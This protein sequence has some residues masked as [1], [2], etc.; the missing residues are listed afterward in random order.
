MNIKTQFDNFLENIRPH[1]LDY[2]QAKGFNTSKSIKCLNPNHED[3][4]PS[5]LCPRSEEDFGWRVHCLACGARLDIFDVYSILEGTPSSGPDWMSKTV[6]PLASRYGIEPPVINL[7]PEQQF[8]QDFYRTFELVS[9][10]LTHD[11]EKMAPEPRAYIESRLWTQETLTALDIGTVSYSLIEENISREDRAKF[12]L[13]RPDVFA[14]KN[15]IFTSRDAIGHPV[16]FFARQPDGEKPKFTSTSSSSLMVD[17]W[18]DRGHL[19]GVDGL[20]RKFPA[21]LLVEGQPD[22]VTAYQSGIKNCVALCGCENFNENHADTL[23]LN[24]VS[25]VV[26][27]F[28]GDEPGQKGIQELLD[29]PFAKSEGLMYEVLVLP[30]GHDPDSFIRAEGKDSFVFLLK[31]ATVSAFEYLLSK[32]SPED[33]LE[34]II[35][36]LVPYI[37]ANKSEILREKMARELSAFLG[38]QASVGA[39]M[40]DVKRVDHLAS[41]VIMERRKLIIKASTRQSEQNPG[42]AEEIYREALEQLSEVDKTGG[43]LDGGKNRVLARITATK[44]AEEKGN[45]GGFEL[46]KGRGHAFTDIL[47]GG[48]WSQGRLII[49]G[50]IENMGKSSFVDDIMWQIVSNPVNNAIGYW[51]TLDDGVIDRQ[52]RLQCCAL[53][54]PEFT[55]NMIK[56]PRY[57]AD[58]RGADEVYELRENSYSKLIEQVAAGR[59]IL[60]GVQDGSTISYATKRLQQL[61]RDNPDKNIVFCLDNIHDVEDYP[62]LDQRQ[63]ITNIVKTIRKRV[64][65]SLGVTAICTAEYR[66]GDPTQAGTDE[67]LAESRALKFAPHLTI[68]LFSDYGVG[69]IPI[70]EATL[71][72]T[73]QGNVL[74]RVQARIG[75]NKITSFKGKNLYFNFFP[76][77]SLF[78]GVP[79]DIAQEEEK[80]R[81]ALVEKIK[82]SSGKTQSR[83]EDRDD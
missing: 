11:K 58:F 42:E 7:T 5:M 73:Y 52:H 70:E 20:K 27:A 48:S 14:A 75:K 34:V 61:R 6:I 78:F 50:A 51:L 40:S 26:V 15:L 13:D 56:N 71:I 35:E 74:P 79:S 22:R 36:E 67:D 49:V 53:G 55:M 47:A 10:L 68:H 76:G 21:V 32:R 64:V 8:C 29:K 19:Y 30:D 24:G 25:L 37:A 77:S 69:N 54:N 28:D 57:Y 82:Y 41:T 66:K 59:I 3:G 31:K 80:K 2:L 23:A 63:R 9:S 62:G 65:D 17:L 16:R 43:V 39:I 44:M 60:E 12:G 4:S 33:P 38:G 1:I 18:R 72:H 45:T 46:L 83:R 81:K